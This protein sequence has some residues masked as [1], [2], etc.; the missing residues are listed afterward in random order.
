VPSI[1]NEIRTNKTPPTYQKTNRFTEGFQTIINAYGT[2]KYQEVNP[3]L[4]TIVTFP[5]LFA[6]MFGDFGHGFLMFCAAS[7]MIYWEKPLKKVRD[8][9]FSMAFYGRYMMGIFSM[10]TGLIYNDV[11]SKSLSIFP[12][13]WE[14]VVPE[15][16]TEGQTVEAALKGDY[17]YPFGLDWMWHSTENDLLFSNSYKMKLSILMGW[18]HMTYSLCLSYINARHFRTPIDIWGV[19]VPGMIFFQ[20]IFGYLVFTIIFKWSIDWIGTNRSP[21]GLLNM[22]IYMFLSPGTI[23]EPLYA[24]QATVQ[25]FLVLIAVVQVPILLLLKPFYLRWEHNKARASGY[26][27]IGETSRVSALDGDD[28]DSNTLDGRASLASDGEGV[29]MITQDIGDEEHEE[30]EFSEVMIHQVIHTI[31]TVPP[32]STQ[33]YPLTCVQNFV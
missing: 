3:G 7:A 23:E 15:G 25:V 33:G 1:I 26:R 32:T 8:E 6:V 21:P 5:F 20:S 14:W 4:P 19:F 24:G 28:D 12:S 18:T 13:A 17:R 16:W 29:A 31:G 2:A 27:G 30:F 22:L 10:Y 9:L 11:F